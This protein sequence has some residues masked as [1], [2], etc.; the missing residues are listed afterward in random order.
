M[1]ALHSDT[2][3][4]VRLMLKHGEEP[5]DWYGGFFL[6]DDEESLNPP[7]F[8]VQQFMLERTPWH[9]KSDLLKQ[10]EIDALR[11]RKEDEERI[12]S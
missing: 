8:D 6:P 2:S 11:F 7:S 12:A 5:L 1:T 4:E 10:A 3:V 9:K